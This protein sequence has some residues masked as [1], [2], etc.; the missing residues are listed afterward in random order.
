MKDGEKLMKPKLL[1]TLRRRGPVN[2]FLVALAATIFS[3]ALAA[4]GLAQIKMEIVGPGSRQFQIAISALKDL[5]ADPNHAISDDFVWVLRRDLT[6]S[7]FFK[8]ISPEAYI[9]DPQ[10]SGYKLGEF[11]FDDWSSINA[12]FLVK[13]AVYQDQ[14]KLAL[15]VYL[16]DVVQRRQALGKRYLGSRDKVAEMARRFADAILEVTTGQRGPFDSKIALVSTGGG[17]F[18]EIFTMS[19][20]GR[21]I[22][23][24]TNNN[25]I[26]LFPSFGRDPNE[27]LYTSYKSGFPALYL[28]DLAHGREIEIR[29]RDGE[30]V[31]GALSPDGRTIA[32]SI[33]QSG[34]TNI[35]LLDRSGTILR[36]LT[37]TNSINVGPAFSA[38]GQ[39]IAFTSDRAGTPQIYLTSVNGGPVRRLTYRG[40]YNTTPAI[41]PKGDRVAYQSRNGNKFDIYLISI[42]G[43]EPTRLTNDDA[44][45]QHPS[46]SPDG[47]YIVYSA[48]RNG[49]SRLYLMLVETGKIVSA[50]TEGN[51]YD[52]SPTW[53]WW[54][55]Q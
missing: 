27:L 13:G 2:V 45:N 17:R 49:S 48:T 6:L 19:V 40:D 18:K 52:S 37:H 16:Y 24:V 30:I 7:S 46:W 1:G 3:V 50:L 15:E 10:Q 54:L 11:N 33:A 43:G 55:A 35:Y 22:Y 14:G 5:G 20:D 28:V 47:R 42:K 39:M 36:T 4:S 41:S 44:S 9:E 26:N 31:D 38:D 25:T 12:E 32:A 29:S 23:R 8:I 34:A 21:D 51:S 53:S